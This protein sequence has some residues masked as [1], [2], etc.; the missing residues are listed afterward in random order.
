MY[1]MSI[2]KFVVC[3]LF[4]FVC[5]VGFFCLLVSRSSGSVLGNF[6]IIKVIELEHDKPTK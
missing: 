1:F 2:H 6:H 5:F 3:F 4:V